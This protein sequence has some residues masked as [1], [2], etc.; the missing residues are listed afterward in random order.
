MQ[1][2]KL[3]KALIVLE[4]AILFITLSILAAENILS[5]VASRQA[6][7]E[8]AIIEQ[9]VAPPVEAIATPDPT[10]IPTP[11]PTPQPTIAP[12]PTP[13]PD[14]TPIPRTLDH[15]H[16]GKWVEVDISEQ[17]V[18]FWRG[19]TVTQEFQC[20]TGKNNRTPLGEHF[21]DYQRSSQMMGDKPVEWVSYINVRNIAFH[22]VKF[23]TDSGKSEGM[24]APA[25]AGCIRMT[26]EGAKALYSFV[27]ESEYVDGN[28]RKGTHVCIHK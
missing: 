16:K 28:L 20:S 11:E 14:P 2:Q 5:A 22:N 18:Y 27:T 13:S 24:G 3:I 23:L 17:M 15:Y 7:P 19:E 21:I 6:H 12:T 26:T 9:V 4:Y 10:P 8:V 1:H 25:S